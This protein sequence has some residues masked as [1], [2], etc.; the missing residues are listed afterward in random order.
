M[1]QKRSQRG[2]RQRRAVRTGAAQKKE[3]AGWQSEIAG[4]SQ[5]AG[6]PK[7]GR[8]ADRKAAIEAD[9]EEHGV[10]ICSK[11]NS[12]NA[13]WRLKCY[14]C[15]LARPNPEEILREHGD[16]HQSRNAKRRGGG[17]KKKTWQDDFK[18]SNKYIFIMEKTVFNFIK[19][20]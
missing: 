4:S 3:R 1:K 11:C 17:K 19:I 15:G 7:G 12:Q 13:T 20:I 2:R 5:T 18:M 6:A 16:R 14:K 10:V 9:M 8:V